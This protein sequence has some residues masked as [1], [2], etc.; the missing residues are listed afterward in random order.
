[1]LDTGISD[2]SQSRNLSCAGQACEAQEVHPQ[3]QGVYIQGMQE[4]CPEVQSLL[5]PQEEA[6]E[7]GVPKMQQASKH[8]L[9]TLDQGE[10][11]QEV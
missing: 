2:I 7:V 5:Q 4:E 6:Q 11:C 10:G 3:H 1:M 8:R 9:L